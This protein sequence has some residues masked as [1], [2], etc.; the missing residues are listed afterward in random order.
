MLL[1]LFALRRFVIIDPGNANLSP[2]QHWPEPQRA[3]E[4]SLEKGPVLVTLEFDIALEDTEAF[5]KAMQPIRHLR[6]RDGALRW[7]LFQDAALPTRW[8]ETCWLTR[9]A[10]IC[11]STLA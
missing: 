6:L 7:N 2:S 10:S 8:I 3:F 5:V 9:G 1:G 4:P 11:A